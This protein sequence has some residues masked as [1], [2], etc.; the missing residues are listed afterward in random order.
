VKTWIHEQGWVLPYT[1][2]QMD[3]WSD[4]MDTLTTPTA[5]RP[6]EDTPDPTLMDDAF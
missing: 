3:E 5:A 4:L 2:A 6:V 1:R